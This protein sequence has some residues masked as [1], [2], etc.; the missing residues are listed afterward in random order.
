M[1]W[2]ILKVRQL[3]TGTHL[4]KPLCLLIE[5]GPLNAILTRV[6]KEWGTHSVTSLLQHWTASEHPCFIPVFHC[7][8]ES[9][10]CGMTQDKTDSPDRN[11]N[12]RGDFDW[13][14]R[15]GSTPTSESGPSSGQGG[16]EFYIY[17]ETS[18]PQMRQDY[19]R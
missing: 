14:R 2:G 11:T 15:S 10:F 8:F 6:T 9:D 13:T 17:A 16:S 12:V 4:R 1:L 7:S 5:K 3:L 18:D 19:T